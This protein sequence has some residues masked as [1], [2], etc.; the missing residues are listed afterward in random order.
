M[1][2]EEDRKG[3][4][5]ASAPELLTILTP[6]HNGA[7]YIAE[8]LDSVLSQGYPNLEYLV[9][10]DGSTDAT[11]RI[12]ERYGE[13]IRVLS[14]AN[15]GETRTVNKGLGL[16]RGEFV[17]IVNADDPLR[18]GAIAALVAALRAH[19]EAVLAYPDWLE[20]DP[21]SAALREVRLPQYDIRRMLEEF[22]VGM[23][24]GV[25]V[26]RRAL[27]AVGLRDTSLRYAG[28][29]DL[30]FRLALHGAFV[31][32]PELLATHRVHPESASVAE[33]GTRMAGE[34]AR[35]ARKCF[36]HERLPA[37]LRRR[38]RAILAHAHFVASHFC[39]PDWK[40]RALHRLKS[41]AYQ[42]QLVPL[43]A[44]RHLLHLALAALP[45]SLRRLLKRILGRDRPAAR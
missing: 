32:L 27:E 25:L 10:D 40:G 3:P 31:H 14:H 36:D 22:N 19:P 44:A 11:P 43:N 13:R 41:M 1:L 6:V 16:A 45:E 18:P 24:P 17:G 12:L 7:G 4:G 35:V 8:T 9:L 37:D 15:I 23:G 38:R 21:R 26:R 39:G 5:M 30:W 28:D 20:I 2:A 33:R 42:P 34:V 29:L